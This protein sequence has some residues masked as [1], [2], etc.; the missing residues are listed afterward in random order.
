MISIWKKIESISIGFSVTTDN[1]FD[2]GSG[3]V[4]FDDVAL[5]G[6]RC[7]AENVIPE[8]LNADCLVNYLD[9]SELATTWLEEGYNTYTA[10]EPNEPV[11][12]YKFDGN[13]LDSAAGG[14]HGIPNG[15][16]TYSN[17]IYGQAISLDGDD[18][19]EL[20]GTINLFSSIDS[21]ITIE[22]W[23]YGFE[24]P[25]RTDTLCCSNFTYGAENP[26]ISIN[27]GCWR[28]PGE[29]NWDCGQ[30]WSFD[31]RLDGNHNYSSEWSQR[32]NHWAFTKDVASGRMQIYQ[33]GKLYDSREDSYTPISGIDTFQIGSGWYGGYDGLIDDFRIYDYA[34]S[35]SEI[36]YSATNGT[37]IFDLPLL[38]PADLNNDNRIDMTDFSLIADNWLE[39]R[40]WP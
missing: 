21:G 31:G 39:N 1:S 40:I 2:S 36:V 10:I 22:F 24:S 16:P 6:S 5:Y 26:V 25:H 9:L 15:N 35:Q 28:A 30:P 38:I 3:T 29:Y 27:L 4:Y 20:S 19:I 23:Q 34:L 13:T 32:W 14:A 11:A 8:D 37:G 18:Y 17:G 33:N 7:F 12:W